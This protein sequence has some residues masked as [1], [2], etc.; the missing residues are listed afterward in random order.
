MAAELDRREG[1][2]RDAAGI[3]RIDPVHGL[4]SME[5]LLGGEH[6]QVG[7]LPIDWS[8]FFEQFPKGT[9]PTWLAEMG[10]APGPRL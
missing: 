6:A 4:M 3:G 5:Q 7:V 9:E 10:A 1:K 2:R 8:E